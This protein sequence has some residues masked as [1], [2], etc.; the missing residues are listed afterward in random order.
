MKIQVPGLFS[1]V[2]LQN[3]IGHLYSLIFTE[4]LIWPSGYI[5]KYIFFS[6]QGSWILL[7]PKKNLI[8]EFYVNFMLCN[9][10]IILR[11]PPKFYLCRS[12]PYLG[13]LNVLPFCVS[14]FSFVYV[15]LIYVLCLCLSFLLFYFPLYPCCVFFKLPSPHTLLS[16]LTLFPCKDY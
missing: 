6:V 10:W 14:F 2:K 7:S 12:E 8:V 5:S 4:S 16:P 1:L 15:M 11:E 3:I 9:D 13:N